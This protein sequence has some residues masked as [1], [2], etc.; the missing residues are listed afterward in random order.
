MKVLVMGGTQFNGLALVN[1]LVNEGHDVT[2][3]NRGKSDKV[4]LPRSVKR[5]YCDRTDTKQM[6]EVLG[7]LEF[8]CIQDMSAY[9]IEDVQLMEEIFRGST[10]HYIFASS[11]AIYDSTK[12]LPITEDHPV[13]DSAQQGDYGLGKIR[14]EEFLV[15]KYRETG[16][17]A[18]IGVLSMMFGPNNIL[19]DREQRMF[20]RILSGRPVLIP[21]DGTTLGQ[22]GHVEDGARAFRM[23]MQ[24]PVTFGKRYNLL[25]DGYYS[26]EG[27]VDTFAKVTGV[28]PQKIFIPHQLM[29]D[30]WTGE[31]KIDMQRVTAN[32]DTRSK[33]SSD[34]VQMLYGLT[35]LIQRLGPNLHHWSHSVIFSTDRLK[36]D[37]GWS[38]R[39]TFSG[40]VEHTYQWYRDKGINDSLEFDFDFEDR[41]IEMVSNWK[42]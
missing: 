24:Q 33:A 19:P 12:L 27:Y 29:D 32:I 7:G 4:E 3:V 26:D 28:S 36:R 20:K 10:G 5:L 30:F 25:S 1:E 17:P 31:A 34:H 9:Q 13:N 42:S 23:M 37:I 21:G 16:F 14:A 18:T 15:R 40:A 11:T 41:L 35:K 2:V 8:D 6:K 22:I 39:Y 38:P